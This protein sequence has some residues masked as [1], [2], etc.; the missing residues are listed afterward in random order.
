MKKLL[1]MSAAVLV[2]GISSA[3]ANEERNDTMK[4][5][6]FKTEDLT[7]APEENFTGNVT[8][9]SM[10]SSEG[11]EYKGAV[12]NFEAG[13]RTNWHKHPKGQTLVITEGEGRAQ[14]E[15]GEVKK[16][17]P[18]DVV[19]FPAG[20]KHWHGAA[21]NSKMSHVAIQSSNDPDEVVTWMEEVTDEQYMSGE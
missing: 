16:L 3:N 15:G 2:L 6:E 13:A 21:P 18:G 5:T 10:F 14:S 19:W 17:M 9:G 12:V 11:G 7:Q 1:V 8:I 20:E 4:V